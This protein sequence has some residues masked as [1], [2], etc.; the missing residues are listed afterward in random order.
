MTD[1][2]SSNTF[3]EPLDGNR[4]YVSNFY[5]ELSKLC[6]ETSLLP[7]SFQIASRL[8]LS[9]KHGSCTIV[10]TVRARVVH[11]NLQVASSSHELDYIPPPLGLPPPLEPADFPDEYHLFDSARL[12]DGMLHKRKLGPKIISI[13]SAEPSPLLCTP[14]KLSW[15]TL[16]LQFRLDGRPKPPTS[17]HSDC[18]LSTQLKALTFVSVLEQNVEPTARNAG[19]SPLTVQVK[20]RFQCQLR[21]SHTPPWRSIDKCITHWLE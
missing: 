11:R 5:F 1:V 6:S 21:K 19:R 18:E 3:G 8:P 16:S 17:K 20:E 15:T 13:S 14:N 7:P 10:Y 12:K 2:K 9:S 4:S